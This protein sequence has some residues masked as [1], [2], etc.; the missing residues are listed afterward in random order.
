MQTNKIL[1][2]N[3]PLASHKISDTDRQRALGLG[4][5]RVHR[6]G[7]AS[8]GIPDNA[9]FW[10]AVNAVDFSSRGSGRRTVYRAVALLASPKEERVCYASVKTIAK[11][12]NMGVTQTRVHLQALVK[13][14]YLVVEGK[15]SGG[16][17]ATSY[18]MTTLQSTAPNPPV[19]V[20]QPSGYRSV[21]PSVTGPEEVIE[22][23]TEEVQAA[24]PLPVPDE[25]DEKPKAETAKLPRHVCPICKHSWPG[26]FD[27]TCYKC[28]GKSSTAGLAAPTPGKYDDLEDDGPST[29]RGGIQAE[30]IRR[31]AT[32][33][34][35]KTSRRQYQRADGSWSELP[36]G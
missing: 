12:A 8:P 2:E 13:E 26:H 35:E 18:R 22:E 23:S 32:A 21:N 17:K 9:E 11:K 24:A 28:D 31:Y 4:P 33:H 15:R 3:P 1:S 10:K 20:S 29:R 5:G 19:T 27:K 14:G 6:G 7:R 16:R 34:P 30:Y 36:G 25:E